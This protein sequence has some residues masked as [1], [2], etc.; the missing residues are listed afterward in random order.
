[1]I[2]S[3]RFAA[4]LASLALALALSACGGGGASTATPATD[5]SAVRTIADPG[6]P[7]LT[8]NTATDGFN[9]INFR[10]QQMGLTVLSRNRQV[11]I[12]AQGHSNYQKINDT[13]THTQIP[14]S[15]GFTGTE[16]ANRLTAA[17]YAFT[18]TTGYAFGEVIAASGDL[19]G[20]ANADDL[21]TAIYHRFVI[22][23]PKFKE[24]GAGSAGLSATGYNFFTVDF[25]A[26]GLS[27]GVGT[28]QLA[29]YP[30]TGQQNVSPI[31]Y[32]DQESP[33][34]I[35][36][37]NAVG[38]PVS[39]HADIDATVLTQRFTITPRGGVALATRLLIHA[40][41][42][43]TPTSAAAIVPLT[44][45]TAATIYDVQFI[46]TVSGVAVTR[47]WSFTTR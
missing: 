13:I 37:Q 7:V 8:G 30:F 1:M 4:H 17:N 27:G 18:S 28:G 12:A 20:A 25:T 19:S 6:A 10:R 33:D 32:S 16:V 43:E 35:P 29:V 9:Q 3:R 14:G 41:D 34:P 21:I 38:Y 42:P 11:D 45:L 15:Q 26:N 5:Q 31:F 23:E 46:G 44:V 39:V 47:N 2:Q 40:D 24:A 36:G 22:F